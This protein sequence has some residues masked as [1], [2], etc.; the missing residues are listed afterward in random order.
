MFDD[1]QYSFPQQGT[2]II[3]VIGVGGGGCNAVNSMYSKG[4]H[5][6]SF[7]VCNTDCKALNDSVVP[8][9]LQLG[10]D[11]LG[12]GNKPDAGR[13]A[14]EDSIEDIKAMLNDG[15]KMVFI[16]AGMGGG[17]GTGAAP[18]IAKTAKEMGILTVGIVTIPFCWEGI[19]KI[20]QALDGV[21]EMSK[22]V[23]ALL[24]INNERL[25]DIYP[26]LTLLDAFAK[27]DDTLCNAARSI[28][29]IITMHGVINLD[30]NDVKTVLLNGG[31]AI[32]STGYGS[33]ESRVSKAI[34]EA[35]HSPLLNN[36]DIYN[37]QKLLLHISFCDDKNDSTSSLMMD[38]MNEVT[39]FMN[40]MNTTDIVETKW[41]LSVDPSLK[42]KVK[43]TILATGFGVGDINSEDM[44]N[45]INQRNAKARKERQERT[46]KEID[47]EIR[48]NNI[49][50]SL[51]KSDSI[52][53]SIYNYIFKEEDLDNDDVISMVESIPTYKRKRDDLRSISDRSKVV[54]TAAA[55]SV[56]SFT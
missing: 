51:R 42:D 12:A 10:Q 49:Y 46:E 26:T 9:R 19:K 44:T 40:K 52:R 54:S 35:L 32:M 30:F 21:E 53:R 15:T 13:K 36:N 4:I 33:G 55:G 29:E 2:S 50:G 3:K 16:T 45:R 41:G 38:E 22:N 28:A 25:S 47:N 23:D 56:I 37:S 5:D 24:V 11:G 34:A 48:R 1:I 27:A 20:D 31:V 39:E 14:A 43:V 17:T 8:S 6:V 7:V 18:V